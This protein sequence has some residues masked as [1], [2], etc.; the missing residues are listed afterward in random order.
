VPEWDMY[1]FTEVRSRELRGY[2]LS[3]GNII[4]RKFIVNSIWLHL[5]RELVTY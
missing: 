1:H 5:Y 4:V 3:E 2:L